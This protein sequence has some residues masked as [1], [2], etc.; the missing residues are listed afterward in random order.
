MTCLACDRIERIRRDDNP[1]FV[2]ELGASYLVL[3]DDQR[4]EGYAI[5]LLKEHREQLV[6]LPRS[7]AATLFDDLMTVARAMTRAWHPRRLN[8]ECLGNDLHHVHWHLVPRYDWDPDP[9][10]PIWVRPLDELHAGS[11][12]AQLDRLRGELRTALAEGRA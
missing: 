8:Y 3:A 12:P 10:R 2:E 5:L 6:D 4:Y 7:V 11:T 1:W 9:R